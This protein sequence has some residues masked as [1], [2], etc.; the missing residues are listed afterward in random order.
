MATPLCSCSYNTTERCL[1]PT[2]GGVEEKKGDGF[3]NAHP[4]R[5]RSETVQR[6]A[7]KTA[8]SGAYHG[9]A[10]LGAKAVLNCCCFANDLT[11]RGL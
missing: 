6:P 3:F 5:K 9:E 1:A 10:E 11:S 2:P 8:R 4:I 7:R